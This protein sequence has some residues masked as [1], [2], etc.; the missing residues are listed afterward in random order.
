M[1]ISTVQSAGSFTPDDDG[2]IINELSRTVELS[3]NPT[4]GNWIVAIAS[5]RNTF[6]TNINSAP[7]V[8][9]TDS[10]SN[11]YAFHGLSRDESGVGC[12]WFVAEVEATGGS[13]E[14]TATFDYGESWQ[15]GGI[16]LRVF[17][18]SGEDIQ[19]A[20]AAGDFIENDDTGS[21]D[22]VPL[23]LSGAEAGDLILGAAAT[24]TIVTASSG[25]TLLHTDT[26]GDEI[27][28]ALRT[29]SWDGDDAPISWTSPTAAWFNG[30]FSAIVL[31]E[32]GEPGGGPEI[33]GITKIQ[34]GHPFTITG[35][36]F[37]ASGNSVILSPTTDHEHSDAETQTIDSEGATEI[38]VYPAVV[39]T[40][41][42][43]G[44]PVYVF[45]E[46][47][48]SNLSDPFAAQIADPVLRFDEVLRDTDS[49]SLVSDT[50]LEIFVVSGS[51]GNREIKHQGT[52]A[53][54][55]S[56]AVNIQSEDFSIEDIAEETDF[57]ATLYDDGNPLRGCG[58]QSAHVVD[59]N[60]DE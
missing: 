30:D 47:G 38:V 44:D 45:V 54:I 58:F 50:G 25:S 60:D 27:L 21:E 18:V 59:R 40:G 22:T 49:G 14:V 6:L 56:G 53:A 17:E 13:F 1:A 42:S 5:Y 35:T 51:A 12:A 7:A 3:T 15:Q 9:V 55:V 33:T 52:N 16:C 37:S 2:S 57:L 26:P 8:V 4:I 29:Y 24:N 34:G 43:F 31:R 11:N 19:V 23:T 28:P 36:D 20:L 32:S 48:D 10:E 41:L 46:D 39:P